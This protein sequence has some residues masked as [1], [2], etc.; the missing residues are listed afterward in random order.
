MRSKLYIHQANLYL[1]SL[2]LQFKFLAIENIDH[3]PKWF[4]DVEFLN[5]NF[6]TCQD[7]FPKALDN[8]HPGKECHAFV[9]ENIFNEIV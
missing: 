4:K 2:G 6:S 1:K 3:G 5:T 9:A 8:Y 7:N